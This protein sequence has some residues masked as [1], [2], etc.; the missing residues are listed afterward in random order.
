MTHSSGYDLEGW[1]KS[2]FSSFF[3]WKIAQWCEETWSN[4]YITQAL[5]TML[6]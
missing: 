4:S 6:W 1:A 5:S 2:L 3:M